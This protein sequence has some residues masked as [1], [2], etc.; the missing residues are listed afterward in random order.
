MQCVSQ[1]VSSQSLAPPALG[2][3]RVPGLG[4]CSAPYAFPLALHVPALVGHGALMWLWI[5]QGPCWPSFLTLAFDLVNSSA[6]SD[7]K[8]CEGSH[9]W[10]R[11]LEIFGEH[12][13]KVCL[14]WGHLV[15]TPCPFPSGPSF[16]PERS[17]TTGRTRERTGSQTLGLSLLFGT[18]PAGEVA[19]G[20]LQHTPPLS[21][22]KRGSGIIFAQ[23]PPR[24]H[25]SFC[26][27]LVAAEKSTLF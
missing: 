18:L 22:P 24:L 7:S 11:I 5:T 8:S 17:W 21:P 15:P 25:T 13:P 9:V 16:P 14:P 23:T 12:P 1:R 10:W 6:G 27:P 19:A 20:S 4:T 26:L 2:Y 3:C